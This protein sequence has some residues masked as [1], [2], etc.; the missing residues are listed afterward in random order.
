MLKRIL[1]LASKMR[2]SLFK[3]SRSVSTL[4]VFSSAHLR[5]IMDM[6]ILSLVKVL[7][8]QF[9]STDV[10]IVICFLFNSTV[11]YP[12]GHSSLTVS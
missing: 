7:Q 12:E 3:S 5:A 2:G 8:V 1:C 10:Q 9:Y 6:G 11:L 4:R